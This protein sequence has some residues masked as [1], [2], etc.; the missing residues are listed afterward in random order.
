MGFRDLDKGS[1]AGAYFHNEDDDYH[2]LLVTVNQIP[3][4]S[5]AV[6]ILQKRGYQQQQ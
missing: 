3:T 4:P 5:I 1:N 2:Y 6:R